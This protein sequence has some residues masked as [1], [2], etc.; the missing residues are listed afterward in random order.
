MRKTYA[1]NAIII[2]W[3]VGWL[4]WLK[5]NPAVGIIVGIIVTAVGWA[6]IRGIENAAQSGAD[7]INNA[8][9]RQ[10]NEREQSLSES[11]PL[12]DIH[13][14]FQSTDVNVPK[15]GESD[16]ESNEENSY[17]EAVALMSRACDSIAYQRAAEQ[18]KSLGDYGNAKELAGK[19]EE[20]AEKCS[21][22]SEA[23]KCRRNNGTYNSAV[24]YMKKGSIDY[25][26]TAYHQFKSISGWLNADVLASVCEK[27]LKELEE[28]KVSV[29]LTETTNGF[30][31]FENSAEEPP[32]DESSVKALRR[33]KGLCQNCGGDFAG[34]KNKSCKIC[35]R[36]KD[37]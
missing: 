19:C 4:L 14:D 5:V 36:Q 32:M 6:I 30:P 11:I 20:L 26:R 33:L 13:S 37:Y 21:D 23:A 18:F 3:L 34:I 24:D 35:G 22:E 25:V 2:G 12:A 17:L 28:A 7:A 29:A 16:F 9:K 8:I 27:K 15:N 10:K 1:P 31:V